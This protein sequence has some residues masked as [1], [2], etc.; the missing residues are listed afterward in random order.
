MADSIAN[1]N[2]PASLAEEVNG[3]SFKG[4]TKREYFAIHAPNEAFASIPEKFEVAAKEL[5]IMPTEYSPSKHYQILVAKAAVKYA[6][7]LLKA[8]G[9]EL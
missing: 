2:L 6:D 8:L 5:G 9:N 1:G 4:L 3:V 7:T